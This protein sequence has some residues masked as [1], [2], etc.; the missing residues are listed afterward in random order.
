VWCVVRISRLSLTG[1]E[2]LNQQNKTKTKK[3]INSSDQKINELSSVHIFGIQRSFYFF[4]LLLEKQ[5]NKKIPL[6][7][8]PF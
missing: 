1:V 8:L 4:F 3:E 6:L 7:K 2:Q 5:T